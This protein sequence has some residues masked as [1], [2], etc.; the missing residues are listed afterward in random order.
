MPRH[1]GWPRW[2]TQARRG[3]STLELAIILPVLAMLTM[4]II[5]LGMMLTSYIVVVNLGR[6]GARIAVD[7]AINQEIRSTLTLEGTRRL[8][9]YGTDAAVLIVRGRT[10]NSD[11]TGGRWTVDPCN[12]SG[13]TL[14]AQAADVVGQ[15]LDGVTG[16]EFVLVEVQFIHR[17]ISRLPFASDVPVS[18]R[19]VIR[20][21]ATNVNETCP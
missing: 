16:Y 17:T 4:G 18:T 6:E 10:A 5:E 19:A 3:Q 9:T 15:Q 2:R 11:G 8:P 12:P 7:G 1:P 21:A 13:W 20:T 14:R